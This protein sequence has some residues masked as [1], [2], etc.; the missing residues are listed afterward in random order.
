MNRT[1]MAVALVGL[2]GALGGCGLFQD[3]Q[4]ISRDLAKDTSGKDDIS[5]GAP[6]TMPP[7]ASLRPPTTGTTPQSGEPTA[8]RTQVILRTGEEPATRTAADT[9]RRNTREAGPTPGEREMLT[10]SGYTGST[11]DVVRRTVDIERERRT[12]GQKD[13]TDRVMRYDPKAKPKEGEEK[14]ARDATGDK[15]VIKRPGEF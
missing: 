14:N 4:T 7:D 13:F 2:A 1:L 11:S 10:R 6:L 15:P 8:R 9:R 3:V 5:G 12:A